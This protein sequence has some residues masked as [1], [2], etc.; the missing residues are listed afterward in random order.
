MDVIVITLYEKPKII[1]GD[2]NND[3]WLFQD[4]LVNHIVSHA[5]F[6]P[7]NLGKPSQM[8]IIQTSSPLG[9]LY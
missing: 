4:R 9:A 2:H 7:R 8:M 3:T 1:Y 6:N 5:E